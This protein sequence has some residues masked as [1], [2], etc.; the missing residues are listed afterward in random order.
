ML[1][2]VVSNA[3]LKAELPAA[4][5]WAN[6]HGIDLIT[7]CSAELIIRAI[8][9]Q[10]RGG[11]RFF[12]QGA[13]DD[14]KELP[15]VWDWWD[16]DWSTNKGRNLSPKPVPDGTPFGSSMFLERNNKGVI[17]APFNRLAYKG[18]DGLHPEWSDP[19][20]WMTTAPQYVT[21]HTV[22]DML[23]SI[24]RDFQHTSDRMR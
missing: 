9:V 11:E 4:L 1:P 12:L 18:Y 19:A 13:F 8:M 7:Q 17:C 20:H 5:A 15:P 10:E 22:A 21:A 6:R 2:Y 16:E 3:A 23:H 24:L 14:Y